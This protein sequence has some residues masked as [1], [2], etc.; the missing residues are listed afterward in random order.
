MEHVVAGETE[1]AAVTEQTAVMTVESCDGVG[2]VGQRRGQGLVDGVEE[3]QNP[4]LL[5]PAVAA[6]I[7]MRPRAAH[8]FAGE[9]DV[10][11]ERRLH[12]ALT[13]HAPPLGTFSITEIAHFY[14]LFF[15]KPV[16][17]KLLCKIYDSNKH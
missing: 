8:V 12:H 13:V 3:P 1:I 10:E 2:D 14:E 4:Q 7:E 16:S 5:V 9:I 15:K 6:Q 11:L 17:R